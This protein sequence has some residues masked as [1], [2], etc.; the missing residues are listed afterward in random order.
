MAKH[1]DTGKAPRS[2]QFE[3]NVEAQAPDLPHSQSEQAADGS[4][5]SEEAVKLED[6][7]ALTEGIRTKAG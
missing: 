3:Q 6:T 7:G 5:T 1:K 2:E 4:E